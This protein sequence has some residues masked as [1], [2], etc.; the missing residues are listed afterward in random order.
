MFSRLDHW[1][2]RAQG[3]LERFILKFWLEGFRASRGGKSPS[4][5]ADLRRHRGFPERMPRRD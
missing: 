1:D 2:E 3:I 4:A 5:L